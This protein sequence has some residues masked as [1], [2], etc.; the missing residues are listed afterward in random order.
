MLVSCA[1][2]FGSAKMY[3]LVNI[4]FPLRILDKSDLH[5]LCK[6]ETFEKKGVLAKR[7]NDPYVME[8]NK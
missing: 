7:I 3:N 4:F 8:E 2:L 5:F 1:W 6:G